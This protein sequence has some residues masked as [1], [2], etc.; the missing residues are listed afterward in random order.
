M[1]IKINNTV[2]EMTEEEFSNMY[3]HILEDASEMQSFIRFLREYVYVARIAG[4]SCK[5]ALLT[6]LHEC[7]WMHCHDQPLSKIQPILEEEM[8]A[9]EAEAY[10]HHEFKLLNGGNEK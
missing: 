8:H 7:L 5:D 6:K 10:R 4:R 2:Y 9:F 1:K 3:T